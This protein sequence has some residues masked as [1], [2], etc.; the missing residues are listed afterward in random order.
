MNRRRPIRIGCVAA[1]V[2][3]STPW[4]LFAPPAPPAALRPREVLI[5][6]DPIIESQANKRLHQ[7]FNWT[8]PSTLTSGYISDLT[9]ASGG[10][11]VQRLTRTLN[12]DEYPIKTDGYRYNDTTFLACWPSGGACHSPDGVSYKAIVRDFDLA[13]KVDSGELDEILVHGAPY[14]GYWESTMAGRNG[15]WC[16][17][18][19]QPR[20]ACSKIFIMMG[21]NY[22]RGVAEMLHST[23]HRS[24][25]IL[26]QTY[27]NSNGYSWSI[28]QSR[29]DWERFAHN[30][31]QSGDA[32]CGTVHYP[33]NAAA[34]YD[35]ANTTFVN[36]NAADWL[37]NFPNLAGTQTSI[38]REAWGGVDYHR[39]FMKW[40]YNHMPHVEGTTTR[41]GMTRQNNWWVYLFDFNRYPESRGEHAPGGVAPV[42]A[43]HPVIPR[44]I[45]T[46]SQ[47][48][49]AP[50]IN[51]AG[52]MAWHASDGSDFEI[53]CGDSDGKNIVRITS[54]S[55][56]DEDPKINDIGRIVWQAF[57]GADYEIFSANAD[58]TGVVQITSNAVPDR[59]PSINNNNKIVWEQFDGADCE[60]W[61]ANADG[62]GLVQITNNNAASG[63]PR[64]DVWPKINNNDRVV[65]YGYDGTDWE[66]FSANVDGTNLVNVSNNTREDEAPE[67]SDA[68]T[69]VWHS[70]HDSTNT[71]IYVNAA[72][73][74]T[75]LRVTTNSYEDWY[76]QI[77]AA[78]YIVWMARNGSDWE[79][80]RARASNG[81]TTALTSNTTHDQYPRIAA[82]G[83]VVW[84]GFD[85]NDWEIYTW[86]D[87]VIRQVTSN[88]HDDRWPSLNETD[89]MAWHAHAAV[90]GGVD[91]T[92]IYTSKYCKADFDRDGDV[93]TLDFE[94][95][96]ACSSGPSVPQSTPSC[97]DALLDG[98]NDV[99]QSDF[100]LF[101]HCYSGDGIKAD[102][103]CGL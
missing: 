33:P 25:S 18:S 79:I 23:G 76:P 48:D 44:R 32:Q 24:E 9:A 57:D 11:L 67:I 63:Y 43:E 52:R 62:T 59:H 100:G 65:W 53:Y 37:A 86:K 12:V 41:D 77:S 2:L 72:T 8:N 56:S 35:Y 19:P 96:A 78:G 74:G 69:V 51:A 30:Q 88:A 68:G 45:T 82:S 39:N 46:N 83:R 70:F 81:A 1:A 103:L 90:T 85:G 75:P 21:F 26:A 20:I 80:M 29:N 66:I 61:S 4:T 55:L 84:Q 47:D 31:T 98:D 17:S 28:T 40:W 92:E 38:N 94:H 95:L 10:L 34:D 36:S 58:G 89:Q 71:E 50:Q 6:Y 14:F 60:I 73:G 91:T 93:D 27:C 22:E 101:Q 97:L 87:G 42:V 64:E 49:W 5:N 7:V 13:R 102:P 54:N 16:N 99:D 15:Y 3:G